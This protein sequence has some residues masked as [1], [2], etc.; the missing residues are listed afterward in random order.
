MALHGARD[1]VA[2][3]K[4]ATLSSLGFAAFR[5]RGLSKLSAVDLIID[6]LLTM[7]LVGGLRFGIRRLAVGGHRGG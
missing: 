5:H 6:W 2:L 1:L 4:A 3:A 7:I